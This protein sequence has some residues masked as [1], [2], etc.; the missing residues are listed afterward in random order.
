VDTLEDTTDTPTRGSAT[1]DTA[2][3]AWM[4]LPLRAFLTGPDLPVT[5]TLTNTGVD[6]VLLGPAGPA[7]VDVARDGRIVREADTMLAV[8]VTDPTRQVELLRAALSADVAARQ[9]LAATAAQRLTELGELR[10]SQARR[11]AEIR[12][13]AIEQYRES[14]ISRDVLDA[15]LS[16]FDLDPYQPRV[17]V[18][19]TITGSFEVDSDDPNEVE[20]D[21]DQN[22]RV[23]LDD[24]DDV[25]DYSDDFQVSVRSVEPVDD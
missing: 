4:Q 19:Y 13:Y 5:V 8:P 21:V 17:K 20:N 11:L 10:T 14:E 7:S 25:V 18:T 6:A 23:D 15:F 3:T 9:T 24:V 2:E 1:A 12:D 16:R 22:L